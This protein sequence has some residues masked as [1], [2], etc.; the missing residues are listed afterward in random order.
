MISHYT[1]IVFISAISMFI[2]ILGVNS[3]CFMPLKRK[4][5]FQLLF[6]LLIIINLAEWLAAGVNGKSGE[7]KNIHLYAKFTEFILAPIIPVVC[8]DAIGGDKNTQVM[9]IPIIINT[10]LQIFSLATNIIFYIDLDNVYHRGVFYPIYIFWVICSILFLVIHCVRFGRKYEFN[11]GLFLMLNLLLVGGIIVAQLLVSELRLDWTCVSISSI[12]LYIY[13]DQLVQ[14]VD[15]LTK[16][17]N[18]RSYN[19]KIENF[20][21]RAAILF[22]DVDNFKNINDTYGHNFGD[23]CLI[24]GSREIKKVFEKYG[25]CYRFGGDEFCV[26]MT[27]NIECTEMLISKYLKKIEKLR[28]NEVRLPSVSVGYVIFEPDKE[29]IDEAINRADKIM[30]DYKE[31]NHEKRIVQVN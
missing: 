2:M 22:F 11:N 19:C 17:L 5:S 13:Y 8:T 1:A 14:Q 26:I 23:E 20:H 30:Y 16:L 6:F 29:T 12:M 31:K 10:I 21:K 3:N 7:L 18:R 4:R 15:D 28:S 25:S 9:S 27:Q 24:K